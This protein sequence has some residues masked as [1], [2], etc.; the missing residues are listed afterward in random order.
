[1]QAVWVLVIIGSTECGVGVEHVYEGKCHSLIQFVSVFKGCVHQY[2]F[3]HKTCGKH[4]KH[5]QNMISLAAVVTTTCGAELIVWPTND[6]EICL[7]FNSHL[8]S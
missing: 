6:I 4:K 7:C 8:H 3:S 5:M 2:L 1:M